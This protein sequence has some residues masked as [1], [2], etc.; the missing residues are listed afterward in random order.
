[1]VKAGLLRERVTFQRLTEGAVDD[2]GNVYS[3]WA[4]LAVRSADLREQK[5]RERITAGALQDRAL[6]TM[7]VRSDSITSA[8]TSADRVIARGITWAIK[9]VMQVDAKDT[10]I[11]F[12]LEKGV[13]S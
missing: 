13:A 12:V 11:E 3:G 7:R 2:Y 6:A 10:Q 8:I 1:M 5:G 9:D 4:D